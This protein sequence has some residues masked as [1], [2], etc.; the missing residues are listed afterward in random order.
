MQSLPYLGLVLLLFCFSNPLWSQEKVSLSGYLRDAETGEELLFANVAIPAEAMG[1]STNE[2]GYYALS[3]PKGQYVVS[4]SYVGY[5]TILDTIDLQADLVKDI[6]LLPESTTV[7]AVVVTDER[8]DENVKSTDMSVLSLDMKEAKKV[9]VIFGEQDIVKTLQLMPGVSPSSEGGSGFFVR[10]GNADQNLILLDEAPVYNAAHLLGFFSV[11]NSDALKDVKLYKGG[12]PAE[13]GGRASSVMD[14]HMK[15][16]NSKKFSGSGGLGLISS[17]L[18]LEG[19]IVK[20]KGSFIVS[21]RR[22]YADLMFQLVADDFDG[23]SLY[24][25]DLNLKANYKLGQ[26]D[27]LYL[28]GYF[29]RDV[30]G[31]D[32]SGLDWG[33]ATLT[34]RWNH[35]FN[36]KLFA[37]TTFVY[38]EY[39][40]GFAVRTDNFDIDLAAGINNLNLKQDYS[41][42]LNPNNNIKFG[43]QSLYYHFRPGSFEATDSETDDVLGSAKL[44]QQYALEN[45]VYISNQHKINKKL[46]M[47]YGLR[48]TSF[49]NIGATTVKTYNEANEAI[50]SVSYGS[51]EFFNTYF[52][53]EPR[54]NAVYLLDDKSS[55]KASYN[56]IYQYL[57]ILS[58]ASS[59]TPTDI[60]APSTQLIKPQYAD[61]VA[62]GYFRNFLDNKLEFSVEGYYKQLGNQV[63]YED[64]AETFLNEDLE[65]ELVFG[66]GRAYGM[67]VFLRKRQGKFTGWVSY[68]LSK[69][70]RQFAD[71]NNGNWFSA[72][73]DRRHDI[74]VVGV[75]DITK[76]WSIS[77]AW[78]YYTGDAIT[79]PSGKYEVDGQIVNLFSSRNGDRMPDYHR[80]DIGATYVFRDSKKWYSDINF[81]V[82][83]AYNR[84]NAYSISF[85]ENEA[86]TGTEAVRL[87]LFGI[88]PSISW[89]FKF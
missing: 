78:V 11:F 16:G 68:T 65:A 76:K 64:G 7:D 54:V 19:P 35:L 61:Q 31:F 89:N 21:G 70:E 29:G 42:Y 87:A 66:Q 72:R 53:L 49:S 26:K 40:Y 73:Q 23:G 41:Y 36:E 81:S 37:N 74:S 82:Y 69:S 1:V 25:Y 20:D 63:D 60:W 77:A 24:F 32:G 46:S 12:V 28:S 59:G 13:F 75:Y 45:A 62:L 22:T 15:N 17:R 71:I 52:G 5:Q 18:T 34:L 39:D 50:D 3:L 84:K 47:N 10:G 2:Y 86:G 56:R 55:I 51:G 8:T 4:Y 43:W 58:N 48:L 27:R 33:N 57:H 88:V 30:F 85:Q 9:P 83:N 14:V 79:F 6:E 44:A 80:L 38:S 67:E